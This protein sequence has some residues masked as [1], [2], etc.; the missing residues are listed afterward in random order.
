MMEGMKRRKNAGLTSEDPY[1]EEQINKMNDSMEQEEKEVIDYN[2]SPYKP[3]LTLMEEL[4]LLGLKDEGHLSFWNDSLSY[5]LRAC[6]M[7]ELALR[8]RVSFAVNKTQTILL[9]SQ[10]LISITKGESLDEFLLDEAIKVM[11]SSREQLDLKNWIAY[12]N[13]ETWNFNKLGYQLKMV[14]ERIAKGLV[15]KGVLRN[16]TRSFVIFEMSVYPLRTPQVRRDIA[17][18]IRSIL[19]LPYEQTLSAMHHPRNPQQTPFL[20][21]RRV[22]LALAAYSAQVLDGWLD[23]HQLESAMAQA[24]SLLSEFSKYPPTSKV[25]GLLGI[26]K[27]SHPIF[28]PYLEL[29][30]A[31]VISMKDS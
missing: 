29:I 21:L 31:V 5:I 10:R 27:E 17:S 12:L 1:N 15:E 11:I 6:I 20:R 3:A 19:T 28:L 23:E 16:D 13:G 8:K 25:L 7:A 9:P 22:L 2:L 24:E 30:S 26:S 18:S 4:F 14:R